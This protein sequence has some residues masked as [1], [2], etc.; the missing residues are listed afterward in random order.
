MCCRWRQTAVPFGQKMNVISN[1]QRVSSHLHRS[2]FRYSIL[3][4]EVKKNETDVTPN[5][6]TVQDL[7]TDCTRN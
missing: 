4:H 2:Q 7:A 3:L 5:I 6:Q 1:L